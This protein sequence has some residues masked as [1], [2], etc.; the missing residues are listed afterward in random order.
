LKP[1]FILSVVRSGST[2][3]CTLLNQHPEVAMLFEADLPSLDRFLWGHLSSGAWTERWEFWNQAPSRH[4]IP[5]E[6]TFVSDIWQATRMTYEGVARRKGATVWGEKTHSCHRALKLAEHFPDARFIFLWRDP[7]S[8]I[9]SIALG[10]QTE[11][12]FRKSGFTERALVGSEQLRRTCDAMKANGRLVHEVCYEELIDNVT[13]CMEKICAFLEIPFLSQTTSLMEADRSPIEG[14]DL[15]H[16]A[17]IWSGRVV[18]QRGSPQL[19]TSSTRDKV[20]RYILRWQQSS[21]SAWPKYHAELPFG[22]RLPGR[23]ELC[24]DQLIY[25][26]LLFWDELVKLT[27]AVV[28]MSVAHLLRSWMRHGGRPQSLPGTEEILPSPN[29]NS[30]SIS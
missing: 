19:V 2:L 27:Y 21:G 12:Y 26:A 25:R 3:L 18:K 13:G 16:H 22:V 24:Y 28:P 4:G 30:R 29:A 7:Q 8:V 23:L 17:G 1:A 15:Q 20:N 11:H 9:E 10:A 5:I 6:P 14:G